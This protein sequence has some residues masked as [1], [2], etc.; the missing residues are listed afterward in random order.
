MYLYAAMHGRCWIRCG[1][2]ELHSLHGPRFA[3][4]DHG[5]GPH[6]RAAPLRH[7]AAV[8]S[9]AAINLPIFLGLDMP[10]NEALSHVKGCELPFWGSF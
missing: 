2:A 5:C 4:E 9:S 10:S 8:S 7:G 1:I 6:I 3:W